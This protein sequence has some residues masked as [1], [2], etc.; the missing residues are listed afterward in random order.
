[1]PETQVQ[2]TIDDLRYER[3]EKQERKLNSLKAELINLGMLIDQTE[4]KLLYGELSDWAYYIQSKILE[5]F[6][7]H[8]HNKLY[9]LRNHCY[10]KNH[11]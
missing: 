2:F 4:R 6:K 10:D 5:E 11:H 8:Y 7:K 3:K 9:Q 1:M